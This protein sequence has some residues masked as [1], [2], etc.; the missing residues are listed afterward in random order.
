MW[1]RVLQCVFTSLH[2]TS[3]SFLDSFDIRSLSLL[4]LLLLLY[5]GWMARAVHFRVFSFVWLSLSLSLFLSLTLSVCL[6]VCLASQ[7]CCV[8]M[9]YRELTGGQSSELMLLV[10]VVVI[11]WL[12]SALWISFWFSTCEL[13]FLPLMDRIES[14]CTSEKSG[15][16][17]LPSVV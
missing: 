15:A 11:L 13:S 4:L 8:H 7:C 14:R 6:S 16:K 5:C 12:R 1:C 3:F 17:V 2:F 10:V 9:I